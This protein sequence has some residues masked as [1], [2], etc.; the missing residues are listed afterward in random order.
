LND[1]PTTG[2]FAVSDN[3]YDRDNDFSYDP[4]DCD[5]N[6]DSE[7]DNVENNKDGGDCDGGCYN[8]ENDTDNEADGYYNDNYIINNS[9]LKGNG[10][11]DP[12]ASN[13]EREF[14]ET[15]VDASQEIEEEENSEAQGG[16]SSGAITNNIYNRVRRPDKNLLREF[17]DMIMESSPHLLS[18]KD[19][20]QLSPASE[21][22]LTENQ[23]AFLNKKS[24]SERDTD[25]H[26]KPQRT[27]VGLSNVQQFKSTHSMKYPETVSQDEE[28]FE[29]DAYAQDEVS[30]QH[31][32]H[33]KVDQTSRDE[34]YLSS[35]ST[36]LRSTDD[37]DVIIL[38]PDD[39]MRRLTD[40][41]VED[42]F[43]KIETVELHR[44][45][46]IDLLELQPSDLGER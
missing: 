11:D 1:I 29:N 34:K 38:R 14:E 23:P 42:V 19:Q 25:S 13:T 12:N 43:S 18:T 3:L 46:H 27:Y 44:T 7:D 24:V 21:D 41:E 4:A 10:N 8:D 2:V 39:T 28:R 9:E 35:T 31:D 6:E 22:I 37:I 20:P 15:K 32:T 45:H 40:E 33:C 36:I 26:S 30:I 5:Y 17:H 16:E